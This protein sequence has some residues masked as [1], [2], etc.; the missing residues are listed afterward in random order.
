MKKILLCTSL[1]FLAMTATGCSETAGSDVFSATSTV[2]S[3]SDKI[4]R[5]KEVD[6]PLDNAL[7]LSPLGDGNWLTALGDFESAPEFFIA[8]TIFGKYAP[9]E[10]PLDITE[11]TRYTVA[12]CPKS[13]GTA[14]I[15]VTAVIYGDDS[16]DYSTAGFA[17]TLYHMAADGSIISQTDLSE[18]GETEIYGI[19][20]FADKVYASADTVYEVNESDGTGKK[21]G[22]TVYGGHLGTDSNGGLCCDIIK[23]MDSYLKIGE[24]TLSLQSCGSPVSNIS[25]GNGYDA[26]FAANTGIFGISGNEITELASNIGLGLHERSISAVY[27]SAEGF[28]ITAYDNTAEKNKIYILTDEEIQEHEQ[29]TLK[30]GIFNEEDD[31]SAFLAQQNG[32]DS[33]VKIEPVYYTQYDVYDKSA[34][35][36][37]STGLDQLNIDIISGNEPDMAVFMDTPQYLSSKGT[38]ADLYTLMDDELSRDDF[39][40]NVLEAFETDGKLYSLPTSF[41]IRT[42]MCKDKFSPVKNQTFD[43]MLRT[44]ENAPEGIRFT[45][46]AFQSQTM[47]DILQGSDFAGN[48]KDGID[49]DNMLRLLEFCE[50]LPAQYDD[51][52]YDVGDDKALFSEFA[53]YQF[54]DFSYIYERFGEPVTVTGYPTESGKGTMIDPI[55]TVVV[56]E[57]CSDKESAWELM[58]CMYSSTNILNGRNAGFP[59]RS[60]IFYKRANADKNMLGENYEQALEAVTSARSIGSGMSHELFGI[61][62][63]EASGYFAGEYTA[64]QAADHIKN[65]TD[66]YISEKE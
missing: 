42:M 51:E 37:K 23:E 39:L 58:K 18:M 22:S 11:N 44:Y 10:I 46:D 4:Y 53:A 2:S 31:F 48:G 15:A 26:V 47:T 62:Y 45:S 25:G 52:Y 29:I 57:S 6:M 54:A 5:L 13:D 7:A 65:R 34:D 14:Y 63:E 35:K 40:P 27:P 16:F 50:T 49:R 8:D 64:E 60:D 20:S 56:F 41:C 12:M 24:K 38:F 33:Y 43:D 66:I 19:C 9:V 28:V 1:A 17:R 59:V 21:P 36:Q 3:K 61:I 55:H 32:S 30:M